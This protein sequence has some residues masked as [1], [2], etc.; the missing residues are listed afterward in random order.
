MGACFK[1]DAASHKRDA[2]KGIIDH[3]RKVIGGANI[4]SGDNNI[5]VLLHVDGSIYSVAAIMP[6]QRSGVLQGHFGA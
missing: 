2:V 1:V 5:A 4:A 3:H 6:G